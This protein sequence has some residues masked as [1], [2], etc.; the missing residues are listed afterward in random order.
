MTFRALFSL[1]SLAFLT[2]FALSCSYIGLR[3]APPAVKATVVRVTGDYL[4]HVAYGRA[5]QLTTMVDW[6]SLLQ[7]GTSSGISREEL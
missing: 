6:D 5:R 7:R 4:T 1:A 3:D 2:L